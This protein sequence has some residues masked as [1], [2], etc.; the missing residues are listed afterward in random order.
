L[1]EPSPVVVELAQD[2]PTIDATDLR[3]AA[4]RELGAPVVSEQAAGRDVVRLTVRI[5]HHRGELEVD[6]T[7][8]VGEPIV[9]RVPL[10]S[11]PAQTLRTAVF[12]IGNLA[13]DEASAVLRDLQPAPEAPPVAPAVTGSAMPPAAL[14]SAGPP[15]PEPARHALWIGV[16]VEGDL[17]ALPTAHDICATHAASYTCVDS[18]GQ[19]AWTSDAAREGIVR[20]ED[21]QVVGGIKS[22]NA[23][24]I[25]AIDAAAS[26]H[27]LLGGRF[28]LATSTYPASGAGAFGHLHVEAR[29][30][31]VIGAHPLATTGLFPMF[32]FGGGLAEY[33]ASVPVRVEVAAVSPTGVV[34]APG[35]TPT[36]TLA[37]AWR[38][39]GPG[40]AS[41]GLG[42]RWA[43]SPDVALSIVPLKATVAFGN[44]GSLLLFTPEITAQFGF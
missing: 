10:P 5:D 27:V 7:Q 23:R 34:P 17:A 3:D 15:P 13:R 39:S 14:P 4:A 41:V 40:F 37:S 36:P 35:V 32:A 31:Y 25:V 20:G 38:F 2:A 18:S 44:G 19:A 9:R 29:A 8:P 43:L 6:R 28:G 11:D 33:S 1:A 30:S 22:A 24:F 16:S 21:D 12:L 42:A 26:D